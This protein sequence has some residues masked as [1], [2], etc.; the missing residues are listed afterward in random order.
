MPRADGDQT[1]LNATRSKVV[2]VGQFAT[3]CKK[4]L[5]PA[6]NA[7]ARVLVKAFT[8]EETAAIIAGGDMP[9]WVTK[10]IVSTVMLAPSSK[11]D[12]IE[13][14]YTALQEASDAKE[15]EPAPL[16]SDMSRAQLQRRGFN[17]FVK[18]MRTE[19]GPIAEQLK[20]DKVFKEDIKNDHIVRQL[21]WNR[22]VDASPEVKSEH[23]RNAVGSIKLDVKSGKATRQSIEADE[24]LALD[25]LHI[26]EVLAK[27]HVSTSAVKSAAKIGA[28]VLAIA[29]REIQDDKDANCHRTSARGNVLQQLL[30]SAAASI[31][32]KA[33]QK[34]LVKSACLSRRQR[35]AWKDTEEL[36]ERRLA[37]RPEGTITMSTEEC[38]E[39]LKKHAVD[40]SKW[41]H[42]VD[43]PFMNL[44]SSTLALWK[45][46]D[47]LAERCAYS[48]LCKKL[49]YGRIGFGHSSSM[50]DVCPACALWDNYL[51]PKLESCASTIEEELNSLSPAFMADFKTAEQDYGW[52]VDHRVT[53]PDWAD[54]WLDYIT[55][56]FEQM[57]DGSVLT[58]ETKTRMHLLIDGLTKKF[59]GEGGIKNLI[60]EWNFHFALRTELRV[61]LDD[62]MLRPRAHWGYVWWD[63]GRCRWI[64]SFTTQS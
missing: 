27:P 10:E 36:P 64:H 14:R 59:N 63:Y 12:V 37:G 56:A 61:A 60:R 22:W 21:A 28:A 47:A 19:L 20:A 35:V 18:H 39:L 38:R 4:I 48:T 9:T 41:C 53:Q 26:Q 33:G 62:T 51:Q 5:A 6:I 52:A 43:A 50:T 46:D 17:D 13:A 30:C 24:A 55:D 7:T 44:K 3:G 11:H 34:E 32:S 54:A 31:D 16:L 57:R 15:S 25:E 40:S 45:S 1:A 2:E 29:K 58:L 23:F 42:R 49:R 8:P